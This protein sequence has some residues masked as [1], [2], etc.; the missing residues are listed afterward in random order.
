M[1]MAAPG[2]LSLGLRIRVFPVHVAKGMVHN[3]IML[4]V[5]YVNLPPLCKNRKL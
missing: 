3:G 2:S 5:A 4:V 1:I